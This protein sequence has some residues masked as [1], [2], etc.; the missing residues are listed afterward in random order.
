MAFSDKVWR[1]LKKVGRYDCCE[2]CGFKMPL[3]ANRGLE[4]SHIVSENDGGKDH[5][6]NA[7][8]LCPNCA[9][10]FDTLLKRKIYKA[11]KLHG[12][13]YSAPKGWEHGEGRGSPDDKI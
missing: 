2:M 7:I 8:V 6:D 1:Q 10:S 4:A 11:F 5:I 12:K 9:K 13:V 3:L